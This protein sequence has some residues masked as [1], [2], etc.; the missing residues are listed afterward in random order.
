VKRFA[1]TAIV[2]AASALAVAGCSGG[3]AEDPLAGSNSDSDAIVVGS[4]NFPENVLLAEIY[5]QAL[6]NSG[7]EVTRQFNIGSR[8]IYYD[9]VA[10]GA[11]T[12]MPE[13]NGALLARVD[14][15]NTAATT[16]DVN[17]ALEEA[18]PEG[19][20]ILASAPGENKDALVVTDETAARYNLKSIADL[21]PVAGELTLG[22]PPEFE[23]RQQGVV[24][25]RDVYGVEFRQFTPT[26]TGGPITIR[27]LGDNTIQVA[28]IFST[29]PSLNTEPFVALEDPESVFGAQ[30]V[31]P[32]VHRS[33]LT[34]ENVAA[35]DAVSEK[36]TTDTLIELVGQVVTDGRDIDVVAEEWLRGNG[37]N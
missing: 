22:G 21:A 15:D 25:L 13:Y 34:D 1:R 37:L 24:G 10:S 20:D 23:T 5:S 27:A 26:D 30:N 4:A 7:A 33:D 14:P 29:D 18:L 8:E 6:E 3:D 36:L 9:Q 31:T 11:I 28:N 19:L 2:L 16:E 12:L 17:T 35:L 32:L